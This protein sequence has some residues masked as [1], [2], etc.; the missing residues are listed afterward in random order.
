MSLT[1]VVRKYFERMP[2]T[3][4]GTIVP[5]SAASQTKQS[6][7]YARSDAGKPCEGERTVASYSWRSVDFVER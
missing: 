7:E 4:Y 2:G 1:A 6:A 3:W 5:H